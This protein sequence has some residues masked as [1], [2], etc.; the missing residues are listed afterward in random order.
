VRAR[1]G[2]AHRF[3]VTSVN[4]FPT[5]SGL[6]SSASAFA[7]LA[8]AASRAAGL[9]LSDTELSLLARRGS[10]SA[11]RSIFGGLV[12]MHPGLPQ[13]PDGS[14]AH[15]EHLADW[16]L[17]LVVAL[18]GTAAKATLSTGGMTLTARTSPYY[19]AWVASHPGDLD[20]AVAAVRRRDLEALGELTERSCLKMHASALASNPGILYWSG[21][22]VEGFHA[23]RKLREKGVATWFTNDAGPHVKALCLPE[24]AAAV[25]KTLSAVPGV[26]KTMICAP[27]K[28]AALLEGVGA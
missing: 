19:P 7:A 17:R 28:G 24:D 8:V 21:A 10:G 26:T 6:A 3:R 20:D 25:E 13:I 4:N 22:T 11:A 15:A 2:V 16:D 18:C 5:A 12:V 23:I 1:A 9:A 27:G 14:D